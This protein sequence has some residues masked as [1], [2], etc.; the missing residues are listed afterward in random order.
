MKLGGQD[1]RSELATAAVFG[2]LSA[3]ER[4]M[5]EIVSDKTLTREDIEAKLHL[6]IVELYNHLKP[7]MGGGHQHVRLEDYLSLRG[8]YNKDVA[9]AAVTSVN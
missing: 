4:V 1:L 8:Y 2:E 5:A 9:G 3:M 6:S 7:V